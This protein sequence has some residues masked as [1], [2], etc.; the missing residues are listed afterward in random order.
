MMSA[1]SGSF[2]KLGGLRNGP[3]IFYSPYY[4]A[5]PNEVPPQFRELPRV[6]LMVGREQGNTFCRG[7]M[8]VISRKM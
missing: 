7:Y 4:K 6:L 2:H 5:P 8:G 1:S 3:P